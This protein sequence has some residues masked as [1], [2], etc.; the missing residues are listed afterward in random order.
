MV[1]KFAFNRWGAVIAKPDITFSKLSGD[2]D[3]QKRFVAAVLA[4]L[5]ACT[6]LPITQGLGEVI[7]GRPITIRFF[8]KKRETAA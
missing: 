1:L 7:A 5:H 3:A 8:S 6:P 2:I 4:A